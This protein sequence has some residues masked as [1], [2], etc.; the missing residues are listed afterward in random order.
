MTKGKGL[1]AAGYDRSKSRPAE[2]YSTTPSH[3]ANIPTDAPYE[4]RVAFL[5]KIRLS[6]NRK[7]K[8]TSTAKQVNCAGLIS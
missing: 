8:G 6:G 3:V 4:D 5:E 2:A 1:V 7:Q